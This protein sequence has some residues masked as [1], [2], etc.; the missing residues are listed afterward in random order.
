MQ[1]FFRR[2]KFLL[3]VRQTPVL[4]L[5]GE[6]QIVLALGLFQFEFRLFDLT[7]HHADSVDG[8]F[9]VL[10]LRF[11]LRRL[12]FEVGQILFDFFEP[13]ARGFVLFFLQGALLD[14]QLH[15]LPFQLIDSRRHRIEFH[16]Q[17]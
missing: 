13:L 11:K 6:I 14:F 3:Q 2:G 4:D 1:R 7:V 8:G 9:F 17:A 16:A 5:G 10:P 15:D 12:L